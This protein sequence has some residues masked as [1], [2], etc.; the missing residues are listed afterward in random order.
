MT[1]M[2]LDQL[3]LGQIKQLKSLLGE[4][5]VTK[6]A[7]QA[8]RYLVVVD[9]GWI[10]AGDLSQTSDG[11]LRLDNAVHVF[12]WESIGFAKVVTDWKSDKVDIRKVAE[13]VE[14]P[15][16]AVVFRIPVPAGWGVK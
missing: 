9:R 13:P 16:D 3:T 8:G 15:Q 14:V 12:R 6:Q 1:N 2:D 11:Y 4:T 7:P 10:F 5:A